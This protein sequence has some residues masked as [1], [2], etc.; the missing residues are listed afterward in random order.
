MVF[1][2]AYGTTNLCEVTL[3]QEHKNPITG[4]DDTPPRK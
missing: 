1:S 4:N 3:G 2:H